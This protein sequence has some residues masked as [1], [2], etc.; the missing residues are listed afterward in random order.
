MQESYLKNEL[1]EADAYVFVPCYYLKEVTKVNK[2]SKNYGDGT[3]LTDFLEEINKK[4]ISKNMKV[5][6]ERVFINHIKLEIISD[7]DEK[8]KSS[9]DAELYISYQNRTKTAVVMIAIPNCDI[10]LTYLFDQSSR[11]GIVILENGSSH[12]LNDYLLDHHSLIK[13]GTNRTFTNLSDKPSLEY[14]KYL[15]SNEVFQSELTKK[16]TLCST[17][18]TIAAE[19]DIAQFTFSEIY[20]YD[21]SVVQ[22]DKDYRDNYAERRYAECLT[23]FIIEFLQ[24]QEATVSRVNFK[25]SEELEKQDDFKIQVIL[26][27][28][29]EFARSIKFWNINIYVYPT[30]Q[31]IV[32]KIAKTFELDQN[33]RVFNDN[34]NVLEHLIATHSVISS[35]RENKMLNYIVLFL[36]LTQVIPVYYGILKFLSE[37]T[38]IKINLSHVLMF[39]TIIAIIGILKFRFNKKLREF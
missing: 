36:T 34:K 6:I 8:D 27:I 13:C 39:V 17:E 38:T 11:D 10:E 20:A 16:S 29:Q 21:T 23:I 24:F 30:T 31:K 37:N 15:L 18:I 22:I 32:E 19:R 35:E 1:I 14:L 7:V 26:K 25:V 28:N 5:D 3:D 4:E 2:N 12:D 9:V 33:M